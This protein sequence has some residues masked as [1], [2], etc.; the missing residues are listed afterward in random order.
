MAKDKKKKGFITEFK[1][2]ISRGSIMD[3]AVGIIIGSAFTAI[4]NSLVND[5]LTPLLGLIS[6]DGFTGLYAGIWANGTA[7]TDI[8]LSNGAVIAAGETTYRTYI[9]YGTFIQS[10]VNFLLIAFSI[11]CLIKFINRLHKSAEEAKE[12]LAKKEKDADA[13]A[14]EEKAVEDHSN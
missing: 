5:I 11:F 8:T 6:K 12:K 2:F 13:S 9:Y 14:T 10:I 3:M 7:A 4:V 1:E